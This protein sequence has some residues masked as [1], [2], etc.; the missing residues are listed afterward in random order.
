M[1]KLTI[2]LL[3]AAILLPLWCDNTSHAAPQLQL[4]FNGIQANCH[5]EIWGSGYIE[6]TMELW[7]GNTMLFSWSASNNL[8]IILDKY[9]DVLVDYSYT[10]KLN[11]TISGVAFPELKVTRRNWG[12]NK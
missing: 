9:C 8:Y 5:A 1:K 10:L 6:A 7:Q 2:I 3:T 11:G 12:M 4:T